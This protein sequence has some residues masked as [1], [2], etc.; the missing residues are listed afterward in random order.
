[1]NYSR[2]KVKHDDDD[3]QQKNEQRRKRFQIMGDS[4]KD[5]HSKYSPSNLDANTALVK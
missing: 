4:H 1:L 5:P 2:N 3:E